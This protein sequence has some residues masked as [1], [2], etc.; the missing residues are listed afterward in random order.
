MY[1][2]FLHGG[3][4]VIFYIMNQK[5]GFKT[6]KENSLVPCYS[7]LLWETKQNFLLCRVA[8]F[9]P[10]CTM[11][12]ALNWELGANR[13]IL[14][15][16]KRKSRNKQNLPLEF[17]TRFESIRPFL[18]LL[19]KFDRP[20][21]DWNFFVPTLKVY[22]LELSYKDFKVTTLKSTFNSKLS[23]NSKTT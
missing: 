5:N 17:C 13:R 11:L 3:A 7:N 20:L 4:K 15:Q 6:L 8:V 9:C 19:R 12:D 2:K 21:L 22:T 1:A 10:L 18:L 14:E 16:K 23:H